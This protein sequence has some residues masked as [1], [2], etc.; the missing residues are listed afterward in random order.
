MT[1]TSP[2]HKISAWAAEKCHFLRFDIAPVK[3][4]EFNKVFHDDVTVLAFKRSVWRSTMNGQTYLETPDCVVVR[5]AGQVFSAQLAHID[6]ENGSVCCEIHLPV[7]RLREI[8]ALS[9]ETLPM[10]DFKQ[11]LIRDPKLADRL[12]RVHTLN[13]GGGC[14]L[15]QSS[16][17]AGFIAALMR[18]SSGQDM[19]LSQKSCSRR[20][21]TIIA[22]LRAHFDRKISLP[23]LA[24]LVQINPYVLLRQFRNEVGVTPHDYLQAY[25]LYRAR[26]FI[27]SGVRL[28]EVALLCGFSDQSH[29]NRHFK[30][31][32]GITPGQLMSA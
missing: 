8:C 13:E 5:D 15:E 17:F 22:Y 3:S 28:S 24:E 7:A 12:F 19:V 11:P 4:L 32:F 2:D 18:A 20:S 21:R 31:R 14:L 25:R 9:E 23:E 16:A 6:A 10:L 29:F 30:T 27:L 26:Q 1:T